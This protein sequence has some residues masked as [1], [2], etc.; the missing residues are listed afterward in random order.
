MY[1][2]TFSRKNVGG[3]GKEYISQVFPT[4]IIFL[5]VVFL[6]SKNIHSLSFSVVIL[7]AFILI[8]LTA[9]SFLF[10]HV[11]FRK[12]HQIALFVASNIFLFFTYGIAYLYLKSQLPVK[13]FGWLGAQKI[14]LIIIIL[15]NVAL[16]LWLKKQQVPIWSFYSL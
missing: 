11:V 9:I 2:T 8:A 3:Y 5:I 12:K 6:Y 4:G 16:I 13:L 7:P 1:T 10:L 14:L 15:V